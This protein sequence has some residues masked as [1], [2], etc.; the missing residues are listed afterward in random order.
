M[1]M[2]IMRVDEALLPVTNIHLVPGGFRV[3][4]IAVGPI[5]GFTGP[6]RLFTASGEPVLDGARGRTCEVAIPNLGEG[7]WATITYDMFIEQ[8]GVDRDR[9]A[10]DRRDRRR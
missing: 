10:T 9:R 8:I 2:G 1:S 3:E 5:E 4:A 6:V 7:S